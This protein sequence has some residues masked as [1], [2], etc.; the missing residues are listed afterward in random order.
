MCVCV[1][2]KENYANSARGTRDDD[3]FWAEVHAFAYVTVRRCEE[4]PL[5]EIW[6]E[7]LHQ[8]FSKSQGYN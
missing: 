4:E 5:K 7:P 8:T 3:E 2:E 1:R 6:V